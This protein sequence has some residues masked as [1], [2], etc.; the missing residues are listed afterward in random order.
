MGGFGMARVAAAG[1]SAEYYR[2]SRG[3]GVNSES[4]SIGNGGIVAEVLFSSGVFATTKN[5]K[6]VIDANRFHISH[7]R[8][9]SSML[10]DTA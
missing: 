3:T 4:R 7:T 10:K 1:T 6:K 8:A 5:K 2:V 9:H